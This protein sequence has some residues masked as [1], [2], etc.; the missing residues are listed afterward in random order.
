MKFFVYTL[1]ILSFSANAAA[2][3]DINTSQRAWFDAVDLDGNGDYTDNPS[4]NVEVSQWSDKSG[5]GNNVSGSGSSRPLYALDTLGTQ[6]HGVKF[7]GTSNSLTDTDDIWSGAVGSSESFVVLTTDLI[8]SS[9]AFLSYGSGNR[10]VGVH[11]PWSNSKTYFDQGICCGAPTR[12][13]GVIPISLSEQYFWHFIGTPTLQSISRDGK[14]YLSDSGASIYD[15]MPNSV[16]SLGGGAT[17]N[18]HNGRFF[19]AL[20]YQTELNNAQRSII[21]SYLSAKWNKAFAGSATYPDVYSGDEVAQGDYDFFVGGIG[22]LAGSQTVG[23]SQGL[24]LSDNNFLSADGKY[25]LAGV[26]YLTT[27][28]KTGV[29]TND[30]PSGY[31]ERSNRSWYIDRTGDNGLINLSFDASAIGIGIDNGAEYGLFH[32]IGTSGVFTAVAS[33]RMSGGVIVFSH[34]PDDGVYTVGKKGVA[35]ISIVKTNQTVEDP[36]NNLLNPKAIP[37]STIDYTL[38]IKNRG[39]VGPDTDTTLIK[40]TLQV[41]LTLFTGDLD[42]NGS[43]FVFT[44]NSCPPETATT[45]S[46]LTLVY[47]DDVVFKDVVGNVATPSM[48]YDP[49]IRSFEIT[50]SGLMNSNYQSDVPCFTI[51]YRTKLE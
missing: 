33:T 7:N 12:L 5:S 18:F 38:T 27:T 17:F 44:D 21:N 37:G 36:I 9:F 40:D 32:R 14:S 10:R 24:T 25:I 29:S 19:E 13:N 22:R 48:D 30:L 31:L 43:P 41:Q 28:P 4:S 20:F 15:V 8:K 1:L 2:P 6:R 47:P 16:F 3:E 39:N 49:S 45:A 51:K 46:N 11:L 34:L 26:D 42:G 35:D 23:T 50:L